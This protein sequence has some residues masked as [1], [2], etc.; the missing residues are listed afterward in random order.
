MKVELVTKTVEVAGFEL[1]WKNRRGY[2]PNHG[3][4]LSQGVVFIPLELFE[5]IC[6]R[7][8]DDYLLGNIPAW[9]ADFQQELALI[10]A[11]FAERETRGTIHGT[12]KGRQVLNNLEQ[13]R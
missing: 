6:E 11:G 9:H 1:P 4:I 7:D 3:K 10:Q 13:S 5:Q 2:P 12:D 8:T